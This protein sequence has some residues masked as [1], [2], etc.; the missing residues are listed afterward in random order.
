[1][2]GR[3]SI[4]RVDLSTEK[5]RKE[6]ISSELRRMY[7]GGEGI[8][9]KLLWDHFLNAD[10]HASPLSPQ[11]MIAVGMGLLG[12]TGL[13][14]GS[15][16]K[17]TFKSPLTHIYGD[18]SS[19]GFFGCQLRW[20]G[21]DHLVITGKAKRPVY[22]VI[23][24]D[25]VEIRNA[26]GMWGKSV[27][28]TD[29]MIKCEL[30]ETGFET[31]CIG[32]AGENLVPYASIVASRERV[33]GRCGGGCVLGS[34]N[35]KAIAALGTKGISVKDPTRFL[36][37][38]RRVSEALFKDPEAR[39]HWK[40]YGTLGLVKSMYKSGYV[41]YRNSQTVMPP[42]EVLEKTNEDWYVK[43]LQTRNFIPCSPGCA[44]AC[45]NWCEIRG[46]HTEASIKYRS[47]HGVRPEYGNWASF[48]GGCSIEDMS[49]VVHLTTK[50]NE[51][52]M[53]TF[54]VGMGVAFLM[55]LWERGI[56]TERDINAWAGEPLS[57]EWG[58]WETVDKVIDMVALKKNTLGEILANGV[59][60]AALRIEK[61]KSVS[62]REYANYGKGGAT[63]EQ[64][65]RGWPE[66]AM[67]MA[68][69]PIGA[70]H[71]KGLGVGAKTAEVFLG[72]GEA[73]KSLKAA[74]KGAAHAVAETLA[75][76]ANSLG[77][78]WFLFGGRRWD[79]TVLPLQLIAD[80]VSAL[81]G[82]EYTEADLLACGERLANLAKAFNSRIGLRRE[83]DTFCHR[84]LREPQVEG[85]AK[86][87]KAEDYI[88]MLKDEYYEYR[89]WDKK[90]SLPTK[91]KLEALEMNDVSDKLKSENAL[92]E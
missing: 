48:A 88:E 37:I 45:G 49:A 7:L 32:Q 57:F 76:I 79:P 78:C 24:D 44:S 83:D 87:W 61:L 72:D 70:H 46:N 34:K 69:S 64:T 81:T 89:G 5:I 62:V 42:K 85:A 8:N 29:D 16:T 28:E 92:I 27:Q 20:A 17:W 26:Q 11:N 31:A 4:L 91:R 47:E 63:H 54:E 2:Y 3:G 41:S 67:G 59:Y 36:R 82:E 55:E 39:L 30:G 66:M 60:G 19:G 86:G 65:V 90:T 77:I 12:A 10:P 40:K 13:G 21:Y 68:V 38:I 6:P 58:N 52:G 75:C 18:T 74:K 43:N 50:C 15:K 1:M 84:W 9:A 71:T 53:D 25:I 22:L 23:I 73:A 35:L 80:A 14:L 51:Y 33:A 56:I